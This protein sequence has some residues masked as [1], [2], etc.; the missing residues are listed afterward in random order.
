M[1]DKY[2]VCH[3]STHFTVTKGKNAA[4]AHVYG[5]EEEA[6]AVCAALN[7]KFFLGRDGDSHWF[8]IPVERREEWEKWVIIPED[9]PSGWDV[10]EFAQEVGGS[11]SGIEFYLSV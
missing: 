5:N 3:C 7:G 2:S 10:P 1:E 9:D 4:K 6:N 8:I 11:P